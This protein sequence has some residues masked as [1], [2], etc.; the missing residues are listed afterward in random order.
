MITSGSGKSETVK[1]FFFFVW[2]A[3]QVA[4]FG[5]ANE[6]GHCIF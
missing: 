6:A 4:D 3:E 1:S 2:L 5:C